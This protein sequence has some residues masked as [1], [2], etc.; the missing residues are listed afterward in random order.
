[1]ALVARPQDQIFFVPVEDRHVW[2]KRKGVYYEVHPDKVR[3]GNRQRFP[4]YGSK[5]RHSCGKN[6]V[7][8]KVIEG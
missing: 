4:G 8:P 7:L 3:S 5:V 6:V 1:M 2:E